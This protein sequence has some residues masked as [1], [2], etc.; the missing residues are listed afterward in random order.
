MKQTAIILFKLWKK[1]N[2]FALVCF[3]VCLNVLTPASFAET[4]P[5]P[6][7]KIDLQSSKLKMWQNN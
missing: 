4:K 2:V 1:Y 6:V 5:L 3:V 7:Y